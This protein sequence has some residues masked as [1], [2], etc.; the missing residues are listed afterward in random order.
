MYYCEKCKEK[1]IAS[2][3]QTIDIWGNNVL[4]WLKRFSNNS[5][6]LIKNN[7]EIIIPIEWRHD[8]YLHGAII[9]YGSIYGG[10]YVYIGKYAN[11][12]Y[13]FNDT[14]VDLIN[15]E[16]LNNYLKNAYLLY[17]KKIISN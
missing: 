3:R 8:L 12:W 14:S 6:K 9:H 4:I 5:G 7:K 10:H 17:Y 13:L 2:K 16:Q 11:K 1:R 15:D